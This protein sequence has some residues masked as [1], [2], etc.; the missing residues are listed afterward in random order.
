MRDTAWCC[1]S[2]CLV[3][4]NWFSGP[5][6]SFYFRII[7]PKQLSRLVV[8]HTTRLPVRAYSAN[9]TRARASVQRVY[10]SFSTFFGFFLIR[11][12]QSLFLRSVIMPD[13]S[14]FLNRVQ[15][16]FTDGQRLRKDFTA[17]ELIARPCMHSSF[18]SFFS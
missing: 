11:K 6:S 3:T 12:I 5:R 9:D 4:S 16:I 14:L 15:L 7:I 18:L 10:A 17:C 1:A 13:N 2:R 8:I